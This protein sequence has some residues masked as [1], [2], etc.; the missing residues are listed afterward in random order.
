MW[1]GQKDVSLITAF[2][3]LWTVDISLV[4]NHRDSEMKVQM[5]LLVLFLFSIGV[6]F[7]LSSATLQHGKSTTGRLLQP[8]KKYTTETQLFPNVNQ[9]LQ[10]LIALLF[11]RVRP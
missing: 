10:D 4:D 3:Q 5:L 1:Y 11:E 7:H 6:P 9:L 8:L 2:I